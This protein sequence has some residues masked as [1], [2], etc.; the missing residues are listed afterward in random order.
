MLIP[1]IVIAVDID[2]HKIALARHNAAVYGVEDRIEFI[3][4]D[5]LKVGPTLRADVVFL[6][7]PWGGPQYLA[8]DIFDLE[9]MMAVNTYPYL[10]HA[11]LFSSEHEFRYLFHVLLVCAQNA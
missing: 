3:V 8:A 5:F 1:C 7:P 6:S 9:T 2:P 10:L 4:G 11:K